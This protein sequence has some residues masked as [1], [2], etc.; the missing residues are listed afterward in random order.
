MLI[1]TQKILYK[2]AFCGLNESGLDWIVTKSTSQSTED[3][4]S[5]PVQIIILM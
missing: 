3:N 4:R 2:F 1:L 5:V